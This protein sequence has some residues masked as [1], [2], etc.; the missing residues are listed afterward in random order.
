MK[1][2]LYTVYKVVVNNRYGY[3]QAYITTNEI[4]T[5]GESTIVYELAIS[6]TGVNIPERVGRN[7]YQYRNNG[8]KD[9]NQAKRICIKKVFKL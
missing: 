6:A 1:N 4:F 5:V 8:I 7:S 2:V 9:F 3:I